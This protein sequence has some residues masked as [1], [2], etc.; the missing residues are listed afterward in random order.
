MMIVK[1]K[2][3]RSR[4]RYKRNKTIKATTVSQADIQ[5]NKQFR[6]KVKQGIQ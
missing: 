2:E 1:Y 3:T 5:T 4:N 6:F